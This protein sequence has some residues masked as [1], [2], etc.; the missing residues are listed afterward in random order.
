MLE[1]QQELKLIWNII[2]RTTS[3]KLGEERFIVVYL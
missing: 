1:N 3:V 2:P